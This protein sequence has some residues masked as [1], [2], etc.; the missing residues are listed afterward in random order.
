[1]SLSLYSA[2]VP[3]F[4]RYLGQL[5]GL[6]DRAEAHC[7]TTGRNV[8]ELLQCRLA[9]DM[10]PFSKQV[11]IA[12]N[13]SFRVC[14]PLAGRA[15]PPYGEV[16]ADLAS[17]RAHIARSQDLLATLPPAD[18]ELAGERLI[19]AEAGEARFTI[20]A[21]DYL[22]QYGLPNH[23]FHLSMAYA[24]LRQQGVP[25]GKADFDGWHRYTH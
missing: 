12:A 16:P 25:V 1:M 4:Q 20:A 17:L 11:E 19:E 15:I 22:L 24:I 10:A 6:L 21:G 13:F 23:L 8:A 9:P 7:Q 5:A 18:F 3:T 2:A 14:Y